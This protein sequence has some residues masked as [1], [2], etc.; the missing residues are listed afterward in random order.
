MQSNV[1]PFYSNPP[2]TKRPMN[3]S[4]RRMAGFFQILNI[5]AS[6]SYSLKLRLQFFQQYFFSLLPFLLL[7]G[8]ANYSLQA[9]PCLLLLHKNKVFFGI[10]PHPLLGMKQYLKIKTQLFTR[11]NHLLGAQRLQIKDLSSVYP[12]LLKTFLNK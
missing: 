7:Q 9:K 6:V 10:Q 5:V 12:A 3:S 2:K 11:R 4:A 1:T 8:L